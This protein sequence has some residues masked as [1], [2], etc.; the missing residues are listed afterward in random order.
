MRLPVAAGEPAR[1]DRLYELVLST[2]HDKA[3]SK[4]RWYDFVRAA[5]EVGYIWRERVAPPVTLEPPREVG[6][7]KESTR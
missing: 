5:V 2:W 6:S 1:R 7:A 4:L 3:G